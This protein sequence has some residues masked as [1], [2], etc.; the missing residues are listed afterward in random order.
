MWQV[1]N[2]LLY[3][4]NNPGVPVFIFGLGYHFDSQ[5]NVTNW[6]TNATA[7]SNRSNA[8]NAVHMFGRHLADGT[9]GT[10]G[11]QIVADLISSNPGI[12]YFDVDMN[13]YDNSETEG[14]NA[15][16]RG[17]HSPYQGNASWVNSGHWKKIPKSSEMGDG[18]ETDSQYIGHSNQSDYWHSETYKFGTE[19]W[20]S[21]WLNTIKN[22]SSQYG[23]LF[24]WCLMD[25]PY[26]SAFHRDAASNRYSV[27]GHSAFCSS[28]E[29]SDSKPKMVGFA[30][31]T[32]GTLAQTT[33]TNLSGNMSILGGNDY[34]YNLALST[35]RRPWTT[36]NMTKWLRSQVGAAT[37]KMVMPWLPG[38]ANYNED[39]GISG[40]CNTCWYTFYGSVVE[41]ARGVLWWMEFSGDGINYQDESSYRYIKDVYSAFT[42]LRPFKGGTPKD[43]DVDVILY[44][45]K[46]GGVES[47]VD[48]VTNPSL[49][50]TDA[51]F[52]Y[53]L[54]NVFSALVLKYN[55]RYRLFIVN[56]ST[57]SA[58]FV[59]RINTDELYDSGWSNAYD[60]S[61]YLTTM[62]EDGGVDK[63]Y[64][65]SGSL[66]G[67]QYRIYDFGAGN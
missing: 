25:E 12:S 64:R 27:Q 51:G 36:V 6:D 50:L 4:G 66:G 59:L 38:F 21:N 54:T 58:D 32:N 19:E 61:G 23:K 43:K 37:D 11:G 17:S 13:I 45:S 2:N 46:V 56:N 31:S 35:W 42:S 62:P 30:P 26:N 28:V 7:M 29:S 57:A 63:R 41:G 22:N 3:T 1:S 20:H 49:S 15:R 34:Q 39:G 44:G 14:T 65:L 10:I 47:G 8:G 24:A 60:H 53:V 40:G 9:N 16:P 55:T 33:W 67:Y 48:W 18:I 5:V 52:P